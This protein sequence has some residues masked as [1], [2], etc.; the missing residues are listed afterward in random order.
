MLVYSSNPTSSVVSRISI[1]I[2]SSIS[3]STIIQV[4]M[5]SSKNSS[6]SKQN[7]RTTVWKT[8]S[9]SG[10]PESWPCGIGDAFHQAKSSRHQKAA[11]RRQG[12]QI[13]RSKNSNGAFVNYSSISSWWLTQQY[14]LVLRVL[15]CR[16]VYP[17][18]D[19][20]IS[21]IMSV[22]HIMY[23]LLHN[24][25]PHRLSSH[26]IYYSFH[27]HSTDHAFTFPCSRPLIL[28]KLITLT[29]NI[30]PS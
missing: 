18:R 6:S 19:H 29:T 5:S 25:V 30:S 23:P 7:R 24:A 26:D 11:K 8:C 1:S 9:T 27:S 22:T 14:V 13:R 16:P 10:V 3:I 12:T 15:L 21:L 4:K 17:F 20:Y 28:H 2:V